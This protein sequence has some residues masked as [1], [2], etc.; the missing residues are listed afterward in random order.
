MARTLARQ[1]PR[2]LALAR[3]SNRDGSPRALTASAAHVAAHAGARGTSTI[4]SRPRESANG[5]AGMRGSLVVHRAAERYDFA[6]RAP[7]AAGH[8]RP[9]GAGD[10][11]IR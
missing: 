1:L 5:I 9:K 6:G 10:E 2:A 3:T 4:S 8:V 7:R 11:C